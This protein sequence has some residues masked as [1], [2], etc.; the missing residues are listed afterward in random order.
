[1]GDCQ[2]LCL[3]RPSVAMATLSQQ[4][5]KL[6]GG[7]GEWGG[8]RDA[9]SPVPAPSQIVNIHDKTVR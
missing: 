3:L 6:Q 4:W 7:G 8:G 2:F 9:G 1:M 5:I